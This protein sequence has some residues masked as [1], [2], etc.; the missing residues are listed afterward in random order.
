MRIAAVSLFE[1]SE[2]LS[3]QETFLSCEG[4]RL[5]RSELPALAC[6]SETNCKYASNIS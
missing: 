1:W 2:Q 5:L 3:V 6:S 4:F